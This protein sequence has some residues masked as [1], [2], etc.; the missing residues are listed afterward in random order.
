[1]TLGQFRV[2]QNLSFGYHLNA[3]SNDMCAAQ[4]GV[5]YNMTYDGNIL[6]PAAY[7]NGSNGRVYL[8]ITVINA[9]L[10]NATFSICCI[11]RPATGFS[12]Y[13]LVSRGYVQSTYRYGFDWTITTAGMEFHRWQGSST[14]YK[15]TN[16]YSYQA[17]HV[18]LLGLTYNKSNGA[19]VFYTH[20]LYPGEASQ[21]ASGGLG[22]GNV[23]FTGS[24][25]QGWNLG[26]RLRNISNVYGKGSMNECL[27]FNDVRTAKWYMMYL[28]QLKGGYDWE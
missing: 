12:T 6:G 10:A 25:D 17:E 14:D 13:P 1:M 20:S 27:M 24:Y 9:L 11:V 2:M 19:C 3:N 21:I 5:D 22:T 28:Q 16:A 7:F 15:L 18:Y 8:A 26:A 4:D 23:A